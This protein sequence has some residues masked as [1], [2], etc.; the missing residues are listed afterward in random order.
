MSIA[1]Y[2]EGLTLD[3]PDDGPII[4][5]KGPG[6]GTGPRA[7]GSAAADA[8]LALP[9]ALPDGVNAAVNAGGILSFVDGVSPD[10]QSDILYSVQFAQRAA[11]GAHDRFAEIRPWYAKYNE[12]LEALGWVTEQDAFA[13]HAQAEG[14]FRMDKAA[15]GVIAGIAS[16]NQLQAITASVTAL[17]QLAEDDGAIAVFDRF[18][19]TDGSGNFQIGAVQRSE[20]GS[21]SMAHGAFYFRAVDRRRKFLFFSWGAN[22]VNFWTAAQKMTLNRAIYATSREHVRRKLGEKAAAYIAAIDLA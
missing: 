13:A 6:S 14:A 9:A 12:I 18:A 19:S 8:G 11:N 21:L 1:S 15:L 17:Q 20:N 16:G 4:V 10:E 7:A 5:R 22:Q 2:I 3:A